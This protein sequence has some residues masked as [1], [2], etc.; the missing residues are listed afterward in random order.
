MPGCQDLTVTALALPPAISINSRWINI[1]QSKH[2]AVT[3]TPS[4]L[5]CKRK[6]LFPHLDNKL[7]DLASATNL[8][9]GEAFLIEFKAMDTSH[10]S[11]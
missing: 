11:K 5:L 1:S 4:T 9:G 10:G 2:R 6:K 7:K 8:A 3:H